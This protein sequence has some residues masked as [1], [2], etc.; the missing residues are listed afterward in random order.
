LKRSPDLIA[1]RLAELHELYCWALVVVER[2][3][4]GIATVR[5]LQRLISDQYIFRYLDRRLQ[6]KVEDGELTLDEG[7]DQAEAG[8][9]TTTMNKADYAIAL[10]QAIRTE[11]IGLSS[12]EWCEEARTIVWFDNAKWGAMSGY[13]D[14]RFMALALANFVRV[15][16][17]SQTT[18][19]VGVM[20]ETGHAR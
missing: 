7:M 5:E 3:N 16:L 4:T 2:N 15:A 14:D 13:H 17:R 6:R 10:E 8:L 11:E 12:E 19:F 1:Y 20:P 9:P 18:G